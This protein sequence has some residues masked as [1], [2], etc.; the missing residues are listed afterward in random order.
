MRAAF[1]D[2]ST[3]MAA[4]LRREHKQPAVFIKVKTIER[5][6]SQPRKNF[7]ETALTELQSSIRDVGL[8]Q[9]L[10]VESIAPGKFRLVAGE[11]RLTAIE[12]L[13][14]DEVSV[15]VRKSETAAERL[16]VQLIENLQRAD[17]QPIEEAQAYQKLIDEFGMR[18][19]DIANLI[20]KS[21][22]RVSEVMRLLDLSDEQREKI[23]TSEVTVSS[24]QL[25][26]IAKAPVQR[27]DELL[28]G[29]L[30]GEMS[31]AK[32]KEERRRGTTR[33]IKRPDKEITLIVVDRARITVAAEVGQGRGEGDATLRA[34][35]LA[36]IDRARRLKIPLV[37]IEAEFKK[38]ASAE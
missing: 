32:L 25:L 20:G 17:L 19:V 27:R 13:G 11:R 23:R 28:A 1:A 38:H 4:G 36:I 34:L 7:D 30:K 24:S 14:W 12:R 5:D 33:S 18:Q 29:A 6:P 16:R 26:E 9:P 3:P 21:P 10:V 35:L 22:G 37:E 15:V 31:V 2:L 8:I